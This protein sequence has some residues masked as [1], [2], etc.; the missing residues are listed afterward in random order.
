MA[1][2]ESRRR[3]LGGFGTRDSRGPEL[4]RV[5][6][7]QI[8]VS[9]SGRLEGSP[10]PAPPNTHCPRQQISCA[11]NALPVASKEPGPTRRAKRG[12]I[13]RLGGKR[14]SERPRDPLLAAKRGRSTRNRS[15]GERRGDWGAKGEPAIRNRGA[16]GRRRQEVTS[17]EEP[18][19]QGSG[20]DIGGRNREAKRGEGS[21]TLQQGLERRASEKEE[22][23]KELYALLGAIRS[24]ICWLDAPADSQG[25][26]EEARGEDSTTPLPPKRCKQGRWAPGEAAQWR[27]RR[28]R[29]EGSAP[30]VLHLAEDLAEEAGDR[31]RRG[32]EEATCGRPAVARGRGQPRNRDREVP[33]KKG[34]RGGAAL[35][36]L[37]GSRFC[38]VEAGQETAFARLQAAAPDRPG[39]PLQ[40][41]RASTSTMQSLRAFAVAESLCS[42]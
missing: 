26:R 22:R 38:Q 4:V 5:P 19:V 21:Y 13:A 11:C 29:R 16:E 9:Q 2:E 23:Q 3:E 10:P 7:G 27:G 32:G 28:G 15:R 39:V 1:Q 6:L 20:G 42:R 40:S 33:G 18:R 36:D 17:Q 25:R 31:L 8:G 37:R 30:V 35:V 24:A 14:A 34:A 41:L 12:R